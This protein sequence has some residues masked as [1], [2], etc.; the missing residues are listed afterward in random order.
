MDYLRDRNQAVN[1]LALVDL[2]LVG[3][4]LVY[5]SA[6]GSCDRR[7][8]ELKVSKYFVNIFVVFLIEKFVV[9]SI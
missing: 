9:Q 7:A 2:V 6:F 5:L 3:F 8:K 4:L 1:T